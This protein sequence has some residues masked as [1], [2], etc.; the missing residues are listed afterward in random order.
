MC[1]QLT[2]QVENQG[3]HH[4]N[5]GEMDHIMKKMGT[6]WQKVSEAMMEA[7]ER[8]SHAAKAAENAAAKAAAGNVSGK[9]F[10]AGNSVMNQMINDLN[11]YNDRQ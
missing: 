5:P 8:A 1:S 3:V 6:N 4:I 9:G 10:V 7:A 2:K 11:D